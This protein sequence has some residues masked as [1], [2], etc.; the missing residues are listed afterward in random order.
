VTADARAVLLPAFDSH[1]L[2][3]TI[4]RFLDSGGVSILIGES[5]EEYVARRMSDQRQTEETGDL[6]RS[7]TSRARSRQ[8]DLLVAVDHELQGIC[9]L[10]VLV[11]PL[12]PIAPAAMDDALLEAVA[13]QIAAAA[14]DLGVNVFLGP[15]LDVLTGSNIWLQGRTF[16]EDPAIVAQRSAAFI[17]G[18]QRTGV[19]AAAK[20]FPG[21]SV[22]TGDP[23]IDEKVRAVM[24]RINSSRCR[25]RFGPPSTPASR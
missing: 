23:A 14:N 25:S 22:T 21:F 9:R 4:A 5:R 8:P 24:V 20:H 17:R 3:D 15:I 10:H 2:P 11:P 1:A 19:A 13:E 12:P 6:V 7:L 16:S 18:V